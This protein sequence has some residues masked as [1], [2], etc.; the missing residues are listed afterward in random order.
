MAAREWQHVSP[1]SLRRERWRSIA[2]AELQAAADASEWHVVE[3]FRI[4]VAVLEAD[5]LTEPVCNGRETLMGRQEL[6]ERAIAIGRTGLDSRS[7]A[8]AVGV[9]YTTA[10]T[11]LRRAG[12]AQTRDEW[13][14]ACRR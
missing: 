11:W 3:A 2:R 6:R 4:V 5:R 12:V 8:R 14:E 9:P 7:V 13:R 10:Y 1:E